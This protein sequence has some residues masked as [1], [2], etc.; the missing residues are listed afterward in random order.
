MFITCVNGNEYID[1]GSLV[2]MIQLAYYSWGETHREG[3]K[4]SRGV[5]HSL[6]RY[7]PFFVATSGLSHEFCH[8]S[9]CMSCHVVLPS[10]HVGQKEGSRSSQHVGQKEEFCFVLLYC[11]VFSC[12]ILATFTLP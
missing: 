9:C 6:K 4:A 2:W 8:V 12:N 10:Q 1:V 5:A 11:I 7:G 3:G